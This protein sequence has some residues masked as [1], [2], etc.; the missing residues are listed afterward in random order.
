[1]SS[2]LD[3]TDSWA[4][5]RLAAALLAV[6]PDL[7]GA[8]LKARAG[9]ARDAWLETF[10]D[11]LPDDKPWR[12]IPVGASDEALLGGIDLASTL[13]TGR[14][15]HR[16]GLLSEIA[17]GVGVLPMA[18]RA[19]PGLAARLAH[20]LDSDDRPLLIALDEGI[21]AEEVL[22]RA[23]SDRLAFH[24]DLSHVTLRDL[25][26]TNIDLEREDIAMAQVRLPHIL[27]GE[28]DK[29][30]TETAAILG[31]SSL[32]APLIALRAARAA[33]ALAGMDEIGPDQAIL[34]TRLV[35]AARAQCVPGLEDEPENAPE[36]PPETDN[37]QQ[38][39]D[40]PNN[41][42]TPDS[43]TEITTEAARISIPPDLLARLQSNTGQS[44]SQS[45]GKAGAARHD[46]RRGRPAG[47]RRGDPS[48]NARLDVL[49]TLRAAAPW[50]RVR[51]QGWQ[52]FMP[53]SVVEVR[54]EDFRVKRFKEKSET[55]TIFAVDASG[56]LALNRL[57]EA[58]GAVELML[59]E[60]YVR[61]DQVAL[62]AFR[63]QEA[64][65]LLPPTRSLTRAKRSLAALP[66]G[67]GTPLAS[68]IA[69][70]EVMA[71]SASR[72][73]R[74]VTIVF[75]T[76]GAANIARDGQSGREAAQADA[77][78]AARHLR[79]AGH[80]VLVVDVSKRGAENAQSVAL[81]LAA[82]YV[83]LPSANPG[84]LAELA[85]ET[86]A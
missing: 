8:V 80:S 44:R 74:S 23:L 73:G 32:R 34:A 27:N 61:R 19:E 86:A 21:E 47:V 50:G 58:K 65:T 15:L 46:G 59:A 1:M 2:S 11:I 52:R 54:R 78:E 64:E 79:A 66:G 49:A 29:A 37:D 35:L 17:D 68:A 28:A 10:R 14:P 42:E 3:T 7:G 75:L 67:G 39:D 5:A 30:L 77:R 41:S 81:D 43:L 76:D 51:R 38:Q 85:R 25:E 84:A 31:I 72:Q 55:L 26:Q 63:G 13:K 57:A 9:P 83:R 22:P 45:S 40:Q 69:S 62:I 60:S 48:E 33:T 56:S 71:H 20:A 18:E 53:G 70:A 82:R 16:A 6:D 24:L 4:E 36:P 12:R